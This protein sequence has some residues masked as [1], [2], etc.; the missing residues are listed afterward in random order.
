VKVVKVDV[1]CKFNK[2][3]G[4]FNKYAKVR[5][6][7]Q[8]LFNTSSYRTYEYDLGQTDNTEYWR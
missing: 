1:G 2:P 5:V 4:Y 3:T 7:H 8:T 6:E